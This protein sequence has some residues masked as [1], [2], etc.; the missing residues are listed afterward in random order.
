[1]PTD[2]QLALGVQQGH[3]G[4]LAE[5]V[6]R[7]HSLLLG[8]LYRMTGG[9]RALA[10]DL[11]QEAFLR[12]LRAIGQYR[13]PRPFKP[14]LYAIATNLA[15][16]HYKRAETR[17]TSRADAVLDDDPAREV[18][19]PEAP[20]PEAVWLAEENARRVARVVH[21]LPDHQREA[22]ILRYYQNLSLNEIAGALDVPVGTVKS[23]LSLGLRRLRETM[24]SE[25]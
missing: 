24:E 12:V 21:A 20:L 25:Q 1:L 11:T 5:L 9:D 2:E 7:H 17:Y 23:R 6:E 3:A 19:D 10:E 4:E 14:W 8:F 22:L 16:D 15:R 13:Y 18:A